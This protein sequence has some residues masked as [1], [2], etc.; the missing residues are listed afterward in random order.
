MMERQSRPKAEVVLGRGDVVL[1]PF[2]FTDLSTEKLRPAVIISSEVSAFPSPQIASDKAIAFTDSKIPS[3][4]ARNTP[5]Y[6]NREPGDSGEMQDPL[7]SKE[8]FS[9]LNGDCRPLTTDYRLL[10]TNR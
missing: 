10:T 4:N 2:P 6:E 3:S 8:V 7:A 5:E 9:M 1:V